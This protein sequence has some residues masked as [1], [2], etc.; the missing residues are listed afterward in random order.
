MDKKKIVIYASK[1]GRSKQIA[2]CFDF[3]IC[4]V[5]EVKQLNLEKYDF[6]LFV[7]PTYG[8]SEI[9]LEM[10]DFIISLRIKNK[11]FIIC[12]LG[13]YFGLDEL[14]WGA[15]RILKNALKNLGWHEVCSSLSLDAFPSIDWSAFY[16]WKKVVDDILSK[17]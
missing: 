4:N 6:F 1:Y 8:D 3:D 14:E 7:C 16:A 9:P 10:E 13:N 15:A 17:N 2:S 11:M 12:E 5:K